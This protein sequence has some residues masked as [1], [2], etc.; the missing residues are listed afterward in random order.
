VFPPAR[1]AGEALECTGDLR[2]GGRWSTVGI[3]DNGSSFRVEGE[4][5]EIDRPHLLV[6]TW[7]ASF[8]GMLK[9]KV[10][11]E[12]EPR[13]VHG[14]Q[15]HGPRRTG[16]GTLVRIRHS[17]FAGD[18]KSAADHGQ[19]WKRVLGWMQAYVEQGETV[20]SRPPLSPPIQKEA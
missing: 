10:R 3:S 5:L 11:C 14:L 4:Y 15:A 20:D 8:A 6:Y 12:L 19:G 17:G 16:T 18:A 9:T 13:D 1:D 2:P 7:L